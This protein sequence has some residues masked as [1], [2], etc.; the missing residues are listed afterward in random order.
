[1]T[2]H[3]CATSCPSV[4]KIRRSSRALNGDF[5]DIVTYAPAKYHGIVAIQLHNHPEVIPLLMARLNQFLSINS[6]QDFYAGKL[7]IVEVHRVRIRQ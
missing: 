6:S 5:A 4:R 1:M 2:W 7:L 3:C